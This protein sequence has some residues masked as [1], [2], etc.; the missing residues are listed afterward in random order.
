MHSLNVRN[1]NGEIIMGLTCYHRLENPDNKL[2]DIFKKIVDKNYTK[3]ILRDINRW[4]RHS[5][6]IL[7]NQDKNIDTIIFNN[8]LSKIYTRMIK[9][10]FKHESLKE[11]LI[12]EKYK[13]SK[14]RY[15]I[16]NYGIDAL[17]EY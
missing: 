14:I 3:N 2:N 12:A 17:D 15:I 13:P 10:L 4:F 7:I 1:T 6:S 9:F 11:E 5:M 16:D 8:E